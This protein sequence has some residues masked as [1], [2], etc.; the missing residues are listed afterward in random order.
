MCQRVIFRVY[1]LSHCP[2]GIELIIV[3]RYMTLEYYLAE[4]TQRAPGPDRESVL[5]QALNKYEK[6]LTRLDE[7]G[8]LS[9]GDKKLLEEYMA[10]PS[11]FTLAPMND[12]AARRETKVR[13]FREEKELK[14][15]LEVCNFW[16]LAPVS[17]H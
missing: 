16:A 4:L 10:N 3:S 5:K 13:R 11:S 8:L 17:G 12:A 7:Y 6:F 2:T 15:K 1:I 9:S 14:Q